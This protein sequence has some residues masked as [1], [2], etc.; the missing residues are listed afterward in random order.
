MA[1]KERKGKGKEKMRKEREQ[2]VT[3]YSTPWGFQ[4]GEAP[5]LPCVNKNGALSYPVGDLIY[6]SGKKSIV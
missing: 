3:N 6:P 5:A 4:G 2:G 1:Q